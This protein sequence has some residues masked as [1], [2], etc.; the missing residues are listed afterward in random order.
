[1]KIRKEVYGVII[2]V[3]VFW[4]ADFFMHFI[5]V[6]ESNYYYISKLGNSILFA[7]IW[8]FAFNSKV[9]WKKILLSVIFGTWISFY[10]IISS[11]S[12]LVQLLGIEAEYAPPPFVIFGVFLNPI[13]WWVFHS[14]AFYIGIEIAGYTVKRKK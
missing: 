2:T 14:I 11:Y 12:G 3:L 8:F 6:G 9:Y 5:G 4:L 10:Y 13:L 1:V 7:V